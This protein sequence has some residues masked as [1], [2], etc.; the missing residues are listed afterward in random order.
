MSNAAHPTVQKM[1]RDA[2]RVYLS[3]MDLARLS[4]THHS[5]LTRLRHGETSPRITTL[6]RC[7]RVIADR[8]AELKARPTLRPEY[9]TAYL[10]AIAFEASAAKRPSSQRKQRRLAAVQAR[11]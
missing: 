8:K 11:A 5:T 4:E 10:T 6:D 2:A 3:L 1:F 9:K 7:Q